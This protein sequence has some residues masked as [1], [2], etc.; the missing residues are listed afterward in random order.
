MQSSWPYL[1]HILMLKLIGDIKK[2]QNH[3]LKRV[4]NVNVVL[5]I[6][7]GLTFPQEQKFTV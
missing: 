5:V 1:L 4:G 7:N 2:N 3:C 6:V